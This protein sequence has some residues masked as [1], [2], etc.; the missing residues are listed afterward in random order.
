MLRHQ[1]ANPLQ[2][3]QREIQNKGTSLREQAIFRPLH[4]VR[5]TYTHTGKKINT[6][7]LTRNAK[8]E[9]FPTRFTGKRFYYS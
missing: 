2:K 4:V 1:A 8:T 3:H 9:S 5:T 7:V 6:T